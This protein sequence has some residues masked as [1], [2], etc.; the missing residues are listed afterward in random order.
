MVI[1]V[2]SVSYES[3]FVQMGDLKTRTT[4]ATAEKLTHQQIVL[5]YM[6]NYRYPS[7][8]YGIDLDFDVSR[9]PKAKSDVIRLPY[10]IFYQC[11]IVH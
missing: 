5:Y 8:Q 6:Y 9:S 10:I 4:A 2:K 7:M 11:L 1:I 3:T